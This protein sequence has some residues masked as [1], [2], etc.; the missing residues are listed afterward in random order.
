MEKKMTDY[1]EVVVRCSLESCRV[2]VF[3]LPKGKTVLSWPV[4]MD[5]FIPDDNAYRLRDYEREGARLKCSKCGGDLEVVGSEIRTASVGG[6]RPE[7][8]LTRDEA[9]RNAM[10]A[11]R[12]ANE[13]DRQ[14]GVRIAQKDL[15]ED[16]F[17][18]VH[19]MKKENAPMSFV[20]IGATSL[21]VS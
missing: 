11:A 12:A 17:H 9:R 13:K 21:E 6:G 14:K 7:R 18:S 10:A 5:S 4:I 8:I 16:G 20:V 19:A 1:K 15:K 3:K 2:G